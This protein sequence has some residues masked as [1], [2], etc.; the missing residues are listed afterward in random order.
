MGPTRS[1]SDII[2]KTTLHRCIKGL[3]WPNRH[4][5]NWVWRIRLIGVRCVLVQR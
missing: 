2:L 1:S 3:G 5:V 4:K